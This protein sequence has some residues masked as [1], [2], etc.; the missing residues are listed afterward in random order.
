VSPPPDDSAHYNGHGQQGC[1]Q[2]DNG[3]NHMS[4]QIP[5]QNSFYEGSTAVLRKARSD[6]YTPADAEFL[7]PSVFAGKAYTLG[8]SSPG[9]RGATARAFAAIPGV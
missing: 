6:N 3:R 2:R 5:F 8:P 7:I 4:H 1:E 9:F